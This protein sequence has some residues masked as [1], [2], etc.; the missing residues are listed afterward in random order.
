M[1]YN[2]DGDGY[3]E[4][5]CKTADG[6]GILKGLDEY[7]V[8]YYSKAAKENGGSWTMYAA[9]SDAFQASRTE[10]YVGIAD[11]KKN[12]NVERFLNGRAPTVSGDGKD[13]WKQVVVSF[14][15]NRTVLYINGE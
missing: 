6:S 12:V 11:N 4:M 14:H 1:V 5:V 10:T 8:S 9:P 3:A 7:T 13:T 2:F 15:K